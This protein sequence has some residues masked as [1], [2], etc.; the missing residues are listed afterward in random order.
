[1]SLASRSVGLA[2]K[3]IS[4]TLVI[5]NLVNV[6]AQLYFSIKC[7]LDTGN[8]FEESFSFLGVGGT[9]DF[10]VYI[11]VVSLS[12]IA[13]LLLLTGLV[14]QM[15][16]LCLLSTIPTLG[17][18]SAMLYHF[19]SRIWLN[20]ALGLAMFDDSDW[21]SREEKQLTNKV[22]G[23]LNLVSLTF[24]L[25]FLLAAIVSPVTVSHDGWKATT[26]E[27]VLR[28]SLQETLPNTN[29]STTVN[30][31]TNNTRDQVIKKT[32]PINSVM[33]QSSAS[34]TP[35]RTCKPPS[36]AVRVTKVTKTECV[37][38]VHPYPDD[39]MITGGHPNQPSCDV[40]CGGDSDSESVWSTY[41]DFAK[42]MSKAG[43]VHFTPT[44]FKVE[45]TTPA[46]QRR[47]KVT[48]AAPMSDRSDPPS[49]ATLP[50]NHR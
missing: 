34:Q 29:N 4:A 26:D 18:L 20:S 23:S 10:I 30:N 39:R 17:C 48:P 40:S 44:Q 16:G 43:R 50:V 24:P 28:Q 45:P 3:I 7:A 41:E 33:L 8:N 27:V 37:A 35:L 22:L 31:N 15:N 2:V 12:G 6:A 46:W 32:S 38:S 13:S 11:V 9:Q 42:S 36:K 47:N 49:Y 21:V 14:A 25:F 5:L 19:I 1:M